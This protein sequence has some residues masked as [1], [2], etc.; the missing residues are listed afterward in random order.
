MVEE[1]D[2]R[3]AT[4][5]SWAVGCGNPKSWLSIKKLSSL[6]TKT[7][8]SMGLPVTVRNYTLSTIKPFLIESEIWK[9]LS[10]GGMASSLA[11]PLNLYPYIRL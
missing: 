3:S 10:I 11:P 8:K 4:P 5:D 9:A 6:G 7:R 1:E 2:G